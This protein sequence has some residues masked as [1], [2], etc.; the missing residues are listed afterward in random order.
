[1]QAAGYQEN[2]STTDPLNRVMSQRSPQAKKKKAADYYMKNKAKP[3]PRDKMQSDFMTMGQAE[4]PQSTPQRETNLQQQSTK[5]F[6][7]DSQNTTPSLRQARVT[8][9]ISPIATK[10]GSRKKAAGHYLAK[11]T[12][13]KSISPSSPKKYITGRSPI[14]VQKRS[15]NKTIDVYQSC[16]YKE[17]DTVNTYLS[18][19]Q[20]LQSRT[21]PSTKG[22]A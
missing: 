22:E 16:K 12:G 8:S 21:H 18:Y 4:T 1:M 15:D 2:T 10:V 17:A 5:T 6:T 9:S 19:S 11:P 13:N 7:Y 20:R 3:E 14:N